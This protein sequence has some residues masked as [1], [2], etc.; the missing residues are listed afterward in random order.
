MIK[1]MLSNIAPFLPLKIDSVNWTRETLHFHGEG[2]SFYTL[3][4]WRLGDSKAMI[5]GCFDDKA[6]KIASYLTDQTIAA[7]SIQDRVLAC[8]PVF[9]LTSGYRLEIFSTDTFE[10]W[11][12]HIQKV[13]FYSATSG[14]PEL[15]DPSSG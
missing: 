10:P 13:G 15:F 1:P 7:I 9:E 14:S 6:E 12:L 4:A 3:S 11:T 2:W 5:L 8:D